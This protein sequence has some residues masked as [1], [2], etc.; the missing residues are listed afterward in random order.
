MPGNL[1]Y[2]EEKLKL[3]SSFLALLRLPVSEISPKKNPPLRPISTFQ[4]T[5]RNLIFGLFISYLM[6]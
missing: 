4:T 1:N 6:I 2:S 5:V 3:S